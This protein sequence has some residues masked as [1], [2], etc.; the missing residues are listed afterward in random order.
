MYNLLIFSLFF[1]CHTRDTVSTS[2]DE[3]NVEYEYILVPLKSLM[4]LINKCPLCSSRCIGDSKY[5]G[6]KYTCSFYCFVCQNIFSWTNDE[7]KRKGPQ[8][9]IRIATAIYTTGLTFTKIQYFFE[10]LNIP[11]I[12]AKSF[13]SIVKKY[14]QPAICQLYTRSQNELWQ[15]IADNPKLVI[16]GDMRANSPGFCAKFGTYI[17]MDLSSNKIINL[18]LVQVGNIIF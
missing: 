15:E 11:H 16:G 3:N 9:N 10:L 6:C 17:V 7:E 2:L 13:Y 8:I 1:L 5:N 14:I 18:E 12:K 4:S